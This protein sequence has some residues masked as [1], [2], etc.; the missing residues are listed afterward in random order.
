[1]TLPLHA[2]FEQ[3]GDIRGITNRFVN[4]FVKRFCDSHSAE[5]VAAAQLSTH[6]HPTV[7]DSHM[8]R[9]DS[10]SS[11]DIVYVQA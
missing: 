5:S 1:M 9:T 8:I 2:G 11:Y 6:D 10:A 3:T 4:V 7:E